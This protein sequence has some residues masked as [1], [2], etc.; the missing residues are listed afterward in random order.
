MAEPKEIIRNF[1]T[2]E[3]DEYL[4]AYFRWANRANW[5]VAHH[6]HIHA[7]AYLARKGFDRAGFFALVHGALVGY[8]RVFRPN[9]ARPAEEVLDVL[10]RRAVRRFTEEDVSL[11]SLKASQAHELWKCLIVAADGIKGPNSPMALSKYLHFLNPS[12]F[13]I[14]DREIVE[15][16]AVSDIAIP[17]VENLSLNARNSYPR[18][19]MYL[20]FLYWAS[21]VWRASQ[22]AQFAALF[23]EHFELEAGQETG[24]PCLLSNGQLERLSAVAFEFVLIGRA[25]RR[26]LLK[27]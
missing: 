26:G 22:P 14:F 9:S 12:L 19:A 1:S 6:A 3:I 16:I 20:D 15:K 17:K 11:A 5:S 13:V 2:T 10:Q 4:R 24:E 25:V 7:A 21:S 18:I 27:C 8:W 23:A